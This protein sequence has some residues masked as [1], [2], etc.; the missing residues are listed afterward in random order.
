MDALVPIFAAGARFLEGLSPGSCIPE[1]ISTG[2]G[3]CPLIPES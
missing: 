1:Q 2:D 3:G